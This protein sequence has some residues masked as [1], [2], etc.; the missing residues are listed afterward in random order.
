MT[1]D[2]LSSCDPSL[3]GAIDCYHNK[4]PT[5]FKR[6]DLYMEF[7]IDLD[8]YVKNEDNPNIKDE[9]EDATNP[10]LICIISDACS[11]HEKKNVNNP[12]M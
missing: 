9:N 10:V 7:S 2:I 1:N 11:A 6:F 5:R 4:L 8:K 3:F 12:E